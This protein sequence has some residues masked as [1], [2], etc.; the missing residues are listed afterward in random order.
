MSGYR[1]EFFHVFENHTRDVTIFVSFGSARIRVCCY[2]FNRKHWH[3]AITQQAVVEYHRGALYESLLEW[4]SSPKAESYDWAASLQR[5][6]IEK[7]I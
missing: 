5:F 1:F 3:E 4:A 2:A 7:F 6:V